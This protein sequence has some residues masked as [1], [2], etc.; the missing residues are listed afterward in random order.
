MLSYEDKSY[1]LTVTSEIIVTSESGDKLAKKKNVSFKKGYAGNN[2]IH[3]LPEAVKQTL[4]GIGTSFTESSAFVLAHLSIDKRRDLM[5]RIY[6]E[7]GAN[8]S[9][10]RNVIGS[11]DF[12]VEGGFSYD[13]V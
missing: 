1:D 12:S 6:R 7:Q 9:M 3:V 11:T 2:V 8:F 5:N 10:A 13:D 4:H